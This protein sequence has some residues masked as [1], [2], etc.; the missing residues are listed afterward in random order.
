ME[1]AIRNDGYV[2]DIL[3]LAQAVDALVE[4]MRSWVESEKNRIPPKRYTQE[5]AD[6]NKEQLLCGRIVMK[7]IQSINLIAKDKGHS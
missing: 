5:I 2:L 3:Q 4:E 1:T 6:L 7:Y